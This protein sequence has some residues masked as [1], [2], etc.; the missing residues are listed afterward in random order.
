VSVVRRDAYR[1]WAV[2]GLAIAL[3]CAL[4]SVVSALPVHTAAVAPEA[5][6]ARMLAAAEHPYQG[7]VE[8]DGRLNLPEL[9]QLGAISSLLSGSTKIR[10]WFAEDDEWRT[11]VLTDTGEQDTYQDSFGTLSWNFETGQITQILGD[12]AVRLPRAD[13]L[14]PP[15]LALRLLHTAAATDKLVAL[16]ARDVAGVAAPGIEIRPVSPDTTI[17]RVDLWADPATGVPVETQV[18][19]RAS[20]APVITSRFLDFSAT[21]PA[22]S[23]VQFDIPDGVPIATANSSDINS[24]LDTRARFPLPDELAGQAAKPV[25]DGYDADV[26]GYG[27]GFATFAV[28]F[29]GDRI[30][31]SALSA[32]TAAG[33]APVTFP[34]GTGRLIR[35]PLLSVLLVRSDRFDRIFL[36]VGLTGPDLLTKAA[37]DLL[38]DEDTQFERC[39]AL[40]QERP[41]PPLPPDCRSVPAPAD[42]QPATGG[43]P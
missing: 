20:A 8:T 19:G 2:V 11:D 10:T 42:P 18:Y 28:L 9:P 29:L 34:N 31:D 23:T 12:P 14:T 7:F 35:T 27:S 40:V 15:K 24:L 6:R 43:N 30:G 16:P 38:T 21:R 32:A 33:A 5:L 37:T 26:S 25:L 39:R 3:L 41:L 13:D 22:D 4:P 36:L 1:R 17:A